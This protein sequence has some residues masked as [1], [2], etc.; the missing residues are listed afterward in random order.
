MFL[1]LCTTC[2]PRS[3]P[4]DCIL[5]FLGENTTIVLQGGL[6]CG[7]DK[8]NQLLIKHSMMAR[9]K[10]AQI[11]PSLNASNV[12]FGGCRLFLTIRKKKKKRKRFLL[13][14]SLLLCIKP[15]ATA[16]KSDKFALLPVAGSKQKHLENKNKGTKQ[17]MQK[18]N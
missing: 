7:T 16:G 11:F 2:S 18:A 5:I 3:S 14:F 15:T 9:G 10:G 1:A 8:T 17:S 12:I 13:F 4:R 6:F